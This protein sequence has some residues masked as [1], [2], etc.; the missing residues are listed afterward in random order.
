MQ[1]TK[2]RPSIKNG[3]NGTSYMETDQLYWLPRL[4]SGRDDPRYMW[5]TGT[6]GKP[7]FVNGVKFELQDWFRAQLPA[8]ITVLGDGEGYCEVYFERALAQTHRGTTGEVLK[9]LS[10]PWGPKDLTQQHLRNPVLTTKTNPFPEGAALKPE[11]V[12]K[13]VYEMET[14]H[15]DESLEIFE[16]YHPSR[17]ILEFEQGLFGRG[18]MNFVK[19]EF[20]SG[21]LERKQLLQVSPAREGWWLSA[22]P[23]HVEQRYLIER[24][25]GRLKSLRKAKA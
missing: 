14:E 22:G 17:V 6:N 21:S 18:G 4:L 15:D 5:P 12:R 19:V 25:Y 9:V 7:R 1:A 16:N 10:I 20:L 24:E 11:D 8:A 23:P 2:W 3:Y 13:R